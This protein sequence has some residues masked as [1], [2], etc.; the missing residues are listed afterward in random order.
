VAD[1]DRSDAGDDPGDEGPADS[2]DFLDDLD[3]VSVRD[4][5]ARDDLDAEDDVSARDDV[6]AW[7][8]P[9]DPVHLEDDGDDRIDAGDPNGAAAL[10]DP[11][12]PGGGAR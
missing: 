4:L 8:V 7:D 12:P 1:G 6:D 9:P 10:D 11:Q 3:D 5:S 2:R